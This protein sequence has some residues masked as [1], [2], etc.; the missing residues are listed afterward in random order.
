MIMTAEKIPFDAQVSATAQQNM[1]KTYAEFIVDSTRHDVRKMLWRLIAILVL[2]GLFFFFTQ[3][4]VF[5]TLMLLAFPLLAIFMRL[6]YRKA[7]LK[8]QALLN[9]LEKQTFHDEIFLYNIT[10]TEFCW[11][12]KGNERNQLNWQNCAFY[13]EMNDVLMV[14]DKQSKLLFLVS[15]MGIGMYYNKLIETVKAKSKPLLQKGI[16]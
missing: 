12:K 4:V 11:Q 16:F 10:S 9:W 13:H 7:R 2:N 15:R 3:L 6:S 8:K 1:W 14:F 5:L